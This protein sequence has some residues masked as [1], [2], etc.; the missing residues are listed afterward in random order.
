MHRAQRLFLFGQTSAAHGVN[1]RVNGTVGITIK[2]IIAPDAANFITQ[3]LTTLAYSESSFVNTL[4][5]TSFHMRRMV[6]IEDS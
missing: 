3:I 4:N 5:L 6:R 2:L 1:N